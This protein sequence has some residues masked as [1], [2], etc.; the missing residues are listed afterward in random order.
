[1]YANV[2]QLRLEPNYTE[3]IFEFLALKV[4]SGIDDYSLNRTKIV[5]FNLTD[6]QKTFLS[7]KVEFLNPGELSSSSTSP[8]LLQIYFIDERMFVS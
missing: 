5:F 3:T 4:K 7:L 2:S 8:D 6:F 1:M